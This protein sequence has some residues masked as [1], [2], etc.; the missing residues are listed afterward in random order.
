[1]E[2][3]WEAPCSA[4]NKT[5]SADSLIEFNFIWPTFFLQIAQQAAEL[6]ESSISCLALVGFTGESPP[7]CWEEAGPERVSL[8]TVSAVKMQRNKVCRE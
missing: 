2:P 8:V 7:S 3:M 5:I 6:K 4:L 1:M